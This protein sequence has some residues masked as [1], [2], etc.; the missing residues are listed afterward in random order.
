M[1]EQ[2]LFGKIDQIGVMVRDMDKAIEYYQSLGIGPFE[3]LKNVAI[4]SREIYGKHIAPD[5]PKLKIRVAQMGPVQFELIEPGEGAYFWRE[6]LDAKGEG[7]NHL[8]FFVDDIDKAEAELAG[9]GCKLLYRSRFQNGG[10]AAYFDTDEVG[11]VLIEFVQWS[12]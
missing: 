6:F 12:A 3:P 1:T 8:G 5:S 7:I 2:S 9:K 11:G 4:I 10:G